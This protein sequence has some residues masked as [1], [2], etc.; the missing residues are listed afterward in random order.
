MFKEWYRLQK[1]KKISQII[2]THPSSQVKEIN[3]NSQVLRITIHPP[4]IARIDQPYA[5]YQS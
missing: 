2:D 1:A 4:Y 3:I 5:S